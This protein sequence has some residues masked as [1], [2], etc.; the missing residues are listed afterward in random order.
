MRKLNGYKNVISGINPVKFAY[1]EQLVKKIFLRFRSPKHTL[2]VYCVPYADEIASLIGA[3]PNLFRLFFSDPKLALVSYFGSYTPYN[4][5]LNDPKTH[6]TARENIMTSYGRIIAPTRTRRCEPGV[7]FKFMSAFY[8]SL[9]CF[10]FAILLTMVFTKSGFR[11]YLNN[12][13]NLVF[14]SVFYFSFMLFYFL[15]CCLF[16]LI[17]DVYTDYRPLVG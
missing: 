10:L 9:A 5:R 7:R 11:H 3:K 12:S 2:Q 13:T 8:K 4:F 17:F 1:I 6:K 15:M 16:H 14:I